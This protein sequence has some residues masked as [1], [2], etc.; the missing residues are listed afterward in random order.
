MHPMINKKI[1]TMKCHSLRNAKSCE[2]NWDKGDMN[3]KLVY[4]R[5]KK[6]ADWRK[7]NNPIKSNTWFQQ[8]PRRLF[9]WSSP[10]NRYRNQINYIC[11]NHRFR[12][13]VTQSTA[14]PGAKGGSDHNP[15]VS[16]RGIRLKKAAQK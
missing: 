13:A 2:I 5:G 4:S 1:S 9:T 6:F 7:T 15:V 10:A 8:P 14:Y 16:R 12:N 11:M 3:T